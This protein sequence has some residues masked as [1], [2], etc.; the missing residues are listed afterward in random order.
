MRS[1]E[2]FWIMI[3]AVSGMWAA[4]AV[5]RTIVEGVVKVRQQ[6]IEMEREYLGQMMTE[7]EEIK[8]RLDIRKR[9]DARESSQVQ[10]R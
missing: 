9:E 5:V 8:A 6:R 1:A 3:I 10:A 2:F 7:I 4:V